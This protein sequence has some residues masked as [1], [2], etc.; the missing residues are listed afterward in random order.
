[1]AK[2]CRGHFGRT[3]RGGN[4]NGK[5]DL[6][7]I[8]LGS[9]SADPASLRTSS[10]LLAVVLL[11]LEFGQRSPMRVQQLGA[12]HGYGPGHRRLLLHQ[13]VRSAAGAPAVPKNAPPYRAL[14]TVRGLRRE[15]VASISR[16][17]AAPRRRP[18]RDAMRRYFSSPTTLITASV[19]LA[20]SSGAMV[21]A[22]VR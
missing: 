6:R 20:S 2:N 8:G 19:S 10:A 3:S 22:G 18:R 21:K 12:M 17:D 13:S 5:I 14:L 1:M 15:I 7:R 9:R 11:I 16:L 4:R